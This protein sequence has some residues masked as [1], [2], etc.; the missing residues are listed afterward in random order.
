MG[1]R[2]SATMGTERLGHRTGWKDEEPKRAHVSFLI[3]YSLQH[4]LHVPV[5]LEVVREAPQPLPCPPLVLPLLLPWLQLLL[6]AWAW[7]QAR[8]QGA[9]VQAS[10]RRQVEGCGGAIHFRVQ[11]VQELLE[12]NILGEILRGQ[13][14]G[15]GI[16][17]TR[18]R[19]TEAVS[20][21]GDDR[22]RSGGHA[23]HRLLV[24]AVTKEK[25]IVEKM[26]RSVKL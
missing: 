15:D 19:K 18:G 1:G 16:A 23:A 5:L 26:P 25:L 11:R 9:L 12:S 3:F 4:V 22:N 21:R 14:E 6:Q 20:V 8:A 7:A 10:P 2:G 17:E 24:I 13:L